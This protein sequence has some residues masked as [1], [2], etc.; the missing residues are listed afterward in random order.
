M[1]GKKQGKKLYIRTYI[2]QGSI[3]FTFLESFRK[4]TLQTSDNKYV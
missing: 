4:K 1:W 3:L 2:S